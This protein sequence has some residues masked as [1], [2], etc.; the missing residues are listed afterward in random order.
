MNKYRSRDK[1]RKNAERRQKASKSRAAKAA[2]AQKRSN[3]LHVITP[4]S[5]TSP[6]S[7]LLQFV[8]RVL[9]NIAP[10]RRAEILAVTSGRTL[11]ITEENEEVCHYERENRT[12]RISCR[13]IE[14]LWAFSYAALIVHDHFF[15]GRDA[16]KGIDVDLHEVP[17]VSEAMTLLEWATTREIR[18]VS[19]PWVP[20]VPM[21]GSSSDPESFVSAADELTLSALGFL[22]WH[23]FSHARLGHVYL[24][25]SLRSIQQERE[26]DA[27]A[28]TWILGKLD[29]SDVDQPQFR[30]RGYAILIAL[31]Q[32]VTSGIHSGKHGGETHPYHFERLMDAL[33]PYFKDPNHSVWSFASVVLSLHIS[34]SKFKASRGPFESFRAGVDAYIALLEDEVTTPPRDNESGWPQTS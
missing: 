27:G 16:S 18:S 22:L 4:A 6:V 31:L 1:G 25:A 29:P 13:T 8:P 26:A 3:L 5:P 33:T 11:L 30:K 19:I 32:L 7:P 34:N 28:T 12:I 24:E 2:S 10:E 20:D 17:E 21:P 9:L 23:E 14:N 15:A